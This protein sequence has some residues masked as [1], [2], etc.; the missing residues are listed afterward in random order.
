MIESTD[1][2]ATRVSLALAGGNALGAYGAG[3]YEALHLRGYRPDLVSG[4]SIGAVNGAIIAGN[5]FEH[6]LAKL[7]A[8]WSEAAAGTATPGL[9]PVTG[10]ARELQNHAH[11]LQTIMFGRPGLFVPRVPGLMSALPG[12][13][14]DVA[15]FDH[16]VSI[17]TLH[18]VIDFDVL[19]AAGVPLIVNTVDMATGEPVRFDSRKEPIG[20]EHLLAS[21]ALAPAYPPVEIGGRTLGDPGLFAN[22]PLDAALESPLER[23]L[24]CFA[25]DLFAPSGETMHDLDSVIERAQDILFASQSQRTLEAR[26]REHRLRH[27]IGMLAR[28][29]GNGGGAGGERIAALAREGT[30]AEL[31]LVFIAYHAASHELAAK[32]L[33]FSRASIEERWR[34]GYD[35]MHRALDRLEAGQCSSQ[36]LGCTWYD[37]RSAARQ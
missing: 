4:A 2:E 37:H 3:A 12:M 34:T 19:N 13:P 6:R 29:A 18:N 14:P 30:S 8:F 10:K 20:P 28:E 35:D 36:G 17:G 32:T 27:V 9:T 26:A 24:L 23:D 21:T 25:V 15:I 5:R 33:E 7:Q 22:L 1:G 31:T 11:A 16:R